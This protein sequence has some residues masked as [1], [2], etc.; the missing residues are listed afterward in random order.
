MIGRVLVLFD[1]P[2]IYPGNGS[3]ARCTLSQKMSGEICNF[4]IS[5]KTH[6]TYKKKIFSDNLIE[7]WEALTLLGW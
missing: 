7:W 3:R 5:P 2:Q 6:H 4:V 1:P